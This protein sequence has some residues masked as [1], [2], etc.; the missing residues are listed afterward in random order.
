MEIKHHIH[1]PGTSTLSPCSKW[2]RVKS[3]GWYLGFCQNQLQLRFTTS[4]MRTSLCESFI[5][6]TW[7]RLPSWSI[8]RTKLAVALENMASADEDCR[9]LEQR[10]RRLGLNLTSFWKSRE[11]KC[12][13][14]NHCRWFPVGILPCFPLATKFTPVW[15]FVC[16][17]DV[18]SHDFELAMTHWTKR[19]SP[20]T[21]VTQRGGGMNAFKRT[22]TPPDVLILLAQLSYLKYLK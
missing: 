14:S 10:Q 3:V 20:S 13:Y 1:V 11:E 2:L 16:A 8:S 5:R 7:M 12:F 21:L 6:D 18:T 19:K 17:H 22:Y 9:Q 4:A 15:V